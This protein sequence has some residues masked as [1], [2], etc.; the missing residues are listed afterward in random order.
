MIVRFHTAPLVKRADRMLRLQGVGIIALGVAILSIWNPLTQPGPKV[1]WFRHA[2]GL[3][4]PSCGMTRGVSLC[5]RGNFHEGSLF[6]PLA[7]PV[8]VLAVLLAFKWGIEFVCGRRLQVDMPRW[9]WR[10]LFVAGFFL[11]L[12]NWIYMLT[13]RREDP[14]SASWLGQLWSLFAGEN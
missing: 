8:L 4:C 5:L 2:V 3:P 10:S 12:A 13:Y 11:V 9:L 1:C 14:F 7:G 6:N